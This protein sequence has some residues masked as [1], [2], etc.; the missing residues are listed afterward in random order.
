MRVPILLAV[1]LLSVLAWGPA[2]AQPRGGETFT[3]RGVEVDVTA[4]TA[5]EARERAF[6]EGQR[7]ALARLLER[8]GVPPQELDA[9]AL[10]EQ[11][12]ADLLRGFQVEQERT[13]PGRYLATLTYSFR[14]DRVEALLEQRGVAAAPPAAAPTGGGA[15]MVLP[16]F[17]GAAGAR[18]WDSPNPWF[19]AWRDFSDAGR[20]VTIMVPFGDLADVADVDVDEA[21]SGS[22]PALEALGSRYAAEVPAVAIADSTSGTLNV[23]L[24]V[25]DAGVVPITSVFAVPGDADDPATLR[26][27]VDETADRLENTAFA[28]R[29]PEVAAAPPAP[30]A[31]PGGA[32]DG[33]DQPGLAV[34]VPIG[35]AADWFDTRRRLER[36]PSVTAEVLSVAPN[37]AVVRLFPGDQ[38]QLQ[39]LLARQGLALV[40]GTE[41]LELRS[42]F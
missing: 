21:L 12:L 9:G 11:T 42:R 26:A 32:G 31:V 36:L 18:L 41:A 13:G 37:E 17:R 14:Q 6:V 23:T 19:E 4:G 16:V 1:A 29:P 30:A 2:S 35:Q 5:S 10:D 27:A 20:S 22:R 7:Q 3:V 8:R 15:V 38:Q 24:N 28:A 34:L 25:Y 39:A 33:A 40:P